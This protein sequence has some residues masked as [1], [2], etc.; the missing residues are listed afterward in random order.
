MSGSKR[1]L[2]QLAVTL[3]SLSAVWSQDTGSASLAGHVQFGQSAAGLIARLYSP[4]SSI[5]TKP[6]AGDARRVRIAFIG[7]DGQFQFSGLKSGTYLLEIYTGQQLLYQSVVSTQDSEPLEIDLGG[8]LIFKKKNWRPADMA[9]DPNSGVFVLDH[10][11]G[12]SKLSPNPQAPQ[13]ETLFHLRRTYQGYAI[14]ASAEFI[15][16]AANS[17][18]GCSLIRYSMSS[19]VTSER[20]LEPGGLCTGIAS[21]GMTIYVTMPTRG[22]ICVLTSW[23]ASCH[24]WGVGGTKTAGPLAFDRIGNRLIVGDESGNAFIVSV[25]NGTNQLLVSNL[26]WITSIAASRTHILVGSGTTVFSISRA[27]DRREIPPPS[28]QSLTGGH[29]V[30]VVVDGSDNAWFA[31]WDK[32]LVE[33]PLPLN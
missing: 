25:A 19:R 26:G 32:E 27:D 14:A 21:D 9:A 8:A 28:L 16:V 31:D 24:S 17:H 5:A 4:K 2:L 10:D 11:G 33:G 18:L 23:D 13:I 12:V 30:G 20:L 7:S 15:Y 3:L 6:A 1:F 22:E 29:I